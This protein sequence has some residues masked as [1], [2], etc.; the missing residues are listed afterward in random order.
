MFMAEFTS[1]PY[2]SCNLGSINL[3][4]FGKTVNDLEHYIDEYVPKAVRFLDNMIT[5]NRLPLDK[6]EQVTKGVRSIGLGVMGFADMLY[7]LGIK[8]NSEEGYALASKLF[9][10]I[11]EV[12]K[13]TSIELAEEKGVYPFWE[14]S[15]WSKLGIRVRNSNFLSV[16]P[17][18]SISF[19]ANT[20]GGLEPNYALVMTRTT[21]EGYK[22]FIV[23]P[24]FEAELKERGLYSEEILDKV[25]AN[26]GSCQGI[27]EIPKDIQNI[28][29]TTYDMTPAEHIKM[30]SIIQSHVDLSCSKTV[31]L[32]NSAT[33]DDVMS[34]Y[35]DAWKKGIKGITI[36]RDGC[37]DNQVLTVG[38]KDA[39]R[40]AINDEGYVDV[41]PAL[42]V[43]YGKRIKVKTGC[44][45]LWLFFFVDDKHNLA[46]IWS[47]VSGGGCK[48]NIESM[49]RLASLC[50]RA[51]VDP[52]HILDQ[53][54]SAFCKTSMDNVGT[55]SCG[56]T[57]AKNIKAFLDGNETI[58]SIP[59]DKVNQVVA[60]LNRVPSLEDNL[61]ERKK[62]NKVMNESVPLYPSLSDS[63]TATLETNHDVCIDGGPH[64]FDGQG[65]Q[66]CV[67]CGY[68]KCG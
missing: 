12:A 20:S 49:S 44:G 25:A 68:S 6:I 3:A 37:R 19:I 29:V 7:I 11:Y 10:T 32:P 55:K 61:E 59:K 24:I 15:L 2:N 39:K 33:V 16:A 34:V 28:F 4:R 66:A 26:N 52:K 62:L 40:V 5:V 67:K 21:N 65:C 45:H 27:K 50:F 23:N 63:Q 14:G 38:K 31:N 51:K 56:H 36:Y 58:I 35:I 64:I 13:R 53:L 22:Y 9:S 47:Q 1:I 54:S 41:E 8:Y 18:G 46:E 30:L 17:T 57:I 42:E 48:A 43:A 60:I